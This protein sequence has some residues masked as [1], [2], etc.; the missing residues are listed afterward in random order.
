MRAGIV[1]EREERPDSHLL[2]IETFWEGSSVE[3]KDTL[4]TVLVAGVGS[5][6]GAAAVRRFAI[7]GAPVALGARSAEYISALSQELN[8]QGQRTIAVPYDVTD[9]SDVASA[10]ARV[11]ERL[12]PI[13][14][15]VYNVGNAHW[16][17]IEELTPY[18]FMAA[19]KAGP[20]GAFLH[21]KILLPDMAKRGGGTVIFTG[22]TSSVRSP[23]H[24]PAFGSAKFGLRGLAM[25]LSRAWSPKG[26]HVAHVLID[27][28]IFSPGSGH[29]DPDEAHIMPEDIAETY[30]Q[31][32]IQPRTAWTFELDLRPVP[33]DLLDN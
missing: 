27:G 7:A 31:L 28:A 30:Y 1:D 25:S 22:A 4:G 33:D 12:G 9:D 2:P 29:S 8:T 19:W 26:I 24:A 21:T 32:A 15:L 3:Q 20:F 10:L 11:E 6:L 23:G 14:T 5:G 13:G 18:Q 17:G 16:A